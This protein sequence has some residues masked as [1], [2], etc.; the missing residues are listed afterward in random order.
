MGNLTDNAMKYIAANLLREELQKL[1]NELKV[2]NYYLD[3]SEQAVGYENALNDFE[4]LID[5]LQQEM[6]KPSYE[7]MKALEVAGKTFASFKELNMNT[8]RAWKIFHEPLE[9][10]GNDLAKLMK[11]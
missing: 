4:L 6:W 10:L 5:S 2:G 8:Q 11:L 9:S 1:K 7:Q 3:N